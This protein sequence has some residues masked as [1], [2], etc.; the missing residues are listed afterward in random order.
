MDDKNAMIYCKNCINILKFAVKL[1][2]NLLA[3]K[4][5]RKI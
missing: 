5:E 1:L 4:V 2:S 3:D